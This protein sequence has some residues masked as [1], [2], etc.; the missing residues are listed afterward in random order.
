MAK[1]DSVLKANVAAAGVSLKAG[2]SFKADVSFENG[3]LVLII[4][5]VTYGWPGFLV[6]LS[7]GKVLFHRLN[8]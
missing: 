4:I 2:M 3:V 6:V 7:N 1:F 5:S 8:F